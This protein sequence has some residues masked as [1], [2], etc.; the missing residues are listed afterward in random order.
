M[1]SYDVRATRVRTVAFHQRNPNEA[2]ITK[3][4]DI[5]GR[6]EQVNASTLYCEHH[7][8]YLELSREL[9]NAVQEG[10]PIRV[11]SSRCS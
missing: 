8:V 2:V 11:A 3:D 9:L 1:P 7:G 10:R 6:Y 4:E 5:S